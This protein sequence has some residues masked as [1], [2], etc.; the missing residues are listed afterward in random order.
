MSRAAHSYW[1]ILNTLLSENE[2]HPPWAPASRGTD[3][4]ADKT[5]TIKSSRLT[6]EEWV[7]EAPSVSACVLRATCSPPPSTASSALTGARSIKWIRDINVS[8][9]PLHHLETPACQGTVT[10]RE[11]LFYHLCHPPQSSLFRKLVP[12]CRV[13]SSASTACNL[14]LLWYLLLS[15]AEFPEV[16]E[17]LKK[18]LWG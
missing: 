6:A 16:I 11:A 7:Q 3:R 13:Y 12:E 17:E 10:Q 5:I 4:N 18:V 9:S 8:Q 1:S 14:W 2:G 15:L